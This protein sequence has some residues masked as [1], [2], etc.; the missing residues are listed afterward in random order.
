M[1][2]NLPVQGTIDRHRIPYEPYLVV[3]GTYESDTGKTGLLM[4]EH[5]GNYRSDVGDPAPA[6]FHDS[7]GWSCQAVSGCAWNGRL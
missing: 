6:E 1:R 2:L 5:G 7:R 3:I 4:G